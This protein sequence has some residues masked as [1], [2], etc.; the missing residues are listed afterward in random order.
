ML[1]S[2]VQF[3]KACNTPSE[4]VYVE[5]IVGVINHMPEYYSY[6]ESVKNKEVKKHLEQI[7]KYR[8]K[9]RGEYKE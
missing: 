8:E 7:I 2:V 4:S 6:E 9:I 1:S 5:D 3:S